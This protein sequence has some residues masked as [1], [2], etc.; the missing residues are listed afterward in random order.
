MRNTITP[1]QQA[2]SVVL[3]R[4]HPTPHRAVL[5]AE[6][7]VG[8][9]RTGTRFLANSPQMQ[10]VLIRAFCFI[11]FISGLWALLPVLVSQGMPLSALGYGLPLGCIGVGAVI[12]AAVMPQVQ[13]ALPVVDQR[14]ALS[15][16]A[17]ALVMVALGHLRTLWLLCLITAAGGVA[18]IMLVSS[19]NVASQEASPA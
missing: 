18:W 7:L 16:I 19:F 11:F 13:R 4:W 5:P 6:R 12:G 3:L 2:G 15:T 17:L 8:A 14:V 10:T 1:N 9:L